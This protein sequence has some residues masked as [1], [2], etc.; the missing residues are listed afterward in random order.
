MKNPYTA[1]KSCS[2]MPSE[3]ASFS[4]D[5]LPLQVFVFSPFLNSDTRKK[6]VLATRHTWERPGP[7]RRSHSSL[8]QSRGSEEQ[9]VWEEKANYRSAQLKE[10][11]GGEEAE[12]E[13]IEGTNALEKKRRP[14]Q[15]RVHLKVVGHGV[16]RD[17]WLISKPAPS[18]SAA[19]FLFSQQK[20][21]ATISRKKPS[22]LNYVHDLFASFIFLI[23]HC[24]TF[25]FLLLFSFSHPLLSKPNTGEI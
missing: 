6:S 11:W 17:G 21:W 22:R 7:K 15:Q 2:R 23:S 16:W 25:A 1:W 5:A 18:F 12:S 4:R 10:V 9:T 3:K 13:K 14:M 19:F 24:M 20:P 8:S